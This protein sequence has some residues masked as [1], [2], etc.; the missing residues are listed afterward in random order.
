[1]DDGTMYCQQKQFDNFQIQ[2]KGVVEAINHD[3][4]SG[5]K[6]ARYFQL[7]NRNGPCRHSTSDAPNVLV[8]LVDDLGFSDLGCFGSELKHLL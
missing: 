5:E 6:E 1:M 2:L 3:M 8:M 7:P 4:H